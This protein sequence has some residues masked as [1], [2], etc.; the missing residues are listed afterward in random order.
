MVYTV[1]TEIEPVTLELLAEVIGVQVDENTYDL[2]KNLTE[3]LT[4]HFY[5]RDTV[6]PQL[7]E[8]SDYEF[9]HNIAPRTM[10]FRYIAKLGGMTSRFTLRHGKP[11]T[12]ATDNRHLP[13]MS[14]S[15][16]SIDRLS[17]HIFVR[18]LTDKEYERLNDFKSLVVRLLGR[19][20]TSSTDN[21]F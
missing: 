12:E 14:K 19:E 2:L 20:P 21:S 7:A 5:M 4:G 6:T 8:H 9:E 3:R 17:N 10:T 15:I 11:L 18:E 1:A 16:G 13:V